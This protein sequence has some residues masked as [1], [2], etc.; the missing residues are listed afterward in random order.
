MKHTLRIASL[1]L[2]FGLLASLPAA[3]TNEESA[4][5][6]GLSS[7]ATP[8]NAKFDTLYA[9]HAVS[10]RDDQYSTGG[11]DYN[12]VGNYTDATFGSVSSELYMQVALAS[13]SG[14]INLDSVKVDTVK[15]PVVIDSVVLTL[16]PTALFPDPNSDYRFLFEVTQLADTVATADTIYR[17]SSTIAPDS[18]R[19]L[20]QG[21][22]QVSPGTKAIR[23]KLNG[24]ATEMIQYAGSNADFVAHAKGMRLRIVSG[25]HDEGMVTLDFAATSTCLTA[26]YHYG[27]KPYTD[28]YQFSLAHHFMHYWHDYSA[29]GV[30]VGSDSI[31]GTNRLYIEPL[32]GYRLKV[33]FDSALTAFRTAH[34]SAV[35]HRARL[36]LPLAEGDWTPYPDRLVATYQSDATGKESYINDYAL[37]GVDGYCDST[38]RLYAINMPRHMQSLL[39]S[40]HGGSLYLSINSRRNAANRAVLRGYRTSNP[41]KLAIVYTE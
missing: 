38:A 21:V 2:G 17:A 29:T 23:M 6:L 22:I 35:V 8:Y 27:P 34:P 39:R 20:Y 5:G 9:N 19:K 3:C 25:Y 24:N 41:L 33:D 14:S 26:Y 11:F 15:Y 37:T 31:N 10:L 18:D 40:G 30:A 13:T 7:E 4:L 32:A 36:M 28:S 1:A 16:I 12:I